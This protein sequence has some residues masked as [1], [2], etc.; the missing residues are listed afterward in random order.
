MEQD[1]NITIAEKMHKVSPAQQYTPGELWSTVRLQT[2]QLDKDRDKN[3]DRKEIILQGNPV[4]LRRLRSLLGKQISNQIKHLTYEILFQRNN[5][6]NRFVLL[7][8]PQ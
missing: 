5:L 4:I 8:P 1:E 6:I 3:W 2:M 7:P